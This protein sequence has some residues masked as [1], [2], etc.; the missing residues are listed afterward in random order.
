MYVIICI[1]PSANEGARLAIGS[2]F[3]KLKKNSGIVHV[4]RNCQ[5]AAFSLYL[6]SKPVG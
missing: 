4:E 1:F 2:E 5:V 3:F 6:L